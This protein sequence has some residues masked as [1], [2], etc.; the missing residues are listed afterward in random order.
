VS[1]GRR[2]HDRCSGAHFCSIT[3]AFLLLLG[4]V[5]AEAQT[6]SCLGPTGANCVPVVTT[7]GAVGATNYPFGAVPITATGTGS[8][9]AISATLAAASGKFT[10][11]CGFSYQGSDG[12]TAVAGNI[13]VTG[14]I[15][16]T[17]NFGYVALA[18][19]AAV[20]QPPPT[21][22]QFNPCI[23]SSAVNM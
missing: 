6:V 23:P 10:Y 17:M 3:A 22:V 18:A 11:I 14:T 12:T 7:Q 15:T 21:I 5:T 13:A 9:G 1:S 8:T 20:P 19:G 4:I 16:G 2:R